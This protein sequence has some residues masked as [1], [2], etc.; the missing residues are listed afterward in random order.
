M[1]ELSYSEIAHCD[2]RF[3]SPF[4]PERADRIAGLLDLRANSRVLD[5]CCGKAEFLIRAAALTGASGLGVDISEH[6]LAVARERIRDCGAGGRVELRCAD[7]T[8][9]VL[10]PGAFDV[11][12]WIGGAAQLGS[13]EKVA[14]HL[15]PAVKPGGL[16]FIADLFW[17]REP[18]QEHVAA[19]FAG[20][21][22]SGILDHAGNTAA[23][24][25]AGLT[26][27]HAETASKAEWDHYEGLYLRGIERWANAHPDDPRHDAF[28]DRAHGSHREYLAWRRAALG[29]GFY[30]YR[31]E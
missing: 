14:R 25:A 23:G 1:T 3:L 18:E 21:G 11:A 22:P 16:V 5:L 30:L 4:S 31:K 10:E 17:A 15:A 9:F 2:H 26:L 12:C 8:T 28:L 7:V 20:D 6:Y 19:F 24:E 27:V 13:F 29:F